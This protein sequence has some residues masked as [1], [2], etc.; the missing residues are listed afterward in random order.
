[1]LLCLGT[2]P[3][4]QG[5]FFDSYPGR[6]HR[7][8]RV[9]EYASGKSVNVARVA[10]C[11]GGL[12]AVGFA[13]GDRG[14]PSGAG[15]TRPASATS[16]LPCRQ[17]GCVRPYRPSGG[18]SPNWSRN[19]AASICLT[20]P[21]VPTGRGPAAPGGRAGAVRVPAGRPATLRRCA[22]PQR[23]TVP[24]GAET[25][26]G[27]PAQALPV[28]GLTGQ[29]NR[30]NCRHVGRR[31]RRLGPRRRSADVPRR[32]SILVTQG[33]GPSPGTA[34]GSGAS[35]PRWA[36]VNH[37]SGDAFAAGLAVDGAGWSRHRRTPWRRVR[38]ANPL[39]GAGGGWSAERRTLTA[40]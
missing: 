31:W 22:G 18:R 8:A 13:G 11:W 36:A 40:R 25:A 20:G 29:L 33:G 3:T 34:A 23:R 16:S 6:R 24:G 39:T 17:S 15:W 30:E 37:R 2:T 35:P 26:A 1:M 10:A 38:G 5:R 21:S 32:R 14:A 4:M 28:A 19:P 12:T 7:A 9:L 27:G